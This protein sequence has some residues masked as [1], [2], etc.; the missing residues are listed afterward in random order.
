MYGHLTCPEI[1]WH[2]FDR[3]GSNGI[4]IKVSWDH[5]VSVSKYRSIEC[6]LISSIILLYLD[7]N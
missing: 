1:F 5:M 2:V 6:Q 4:D 3:A 7:T